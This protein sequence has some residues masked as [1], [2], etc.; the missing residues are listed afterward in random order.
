MALLVSL[1]CTIAAQQ[2]SEATQAPLN[3]APYRVG[4]RLTYN[5][6]YSRYPSAGH[7]ELSVTGRGTIFNNDGIHYRAHLQTTGIVNVA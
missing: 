3:E 5:V 2:T 1:T 4:E 7:I 6:Q